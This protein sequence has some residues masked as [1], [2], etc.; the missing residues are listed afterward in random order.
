[1]EARVIIAFILSIVVFV[2]WSYLF[3]PKPKPIDPQTSTSTTIPG[4]PAQGTG[5]QARKTRT[6]QP[7]GQTQAA[8]AVRAGAYNGPIN[9]IEVNTDSYTARFTEDGGR[10]VSFKL[11][12]YREE[13]K[14]DSPPKELVTVESVRELPLKTFFLNNSRPGLKNA[15]FAANKKNLLLDAES[16]PESLTFTYDEPG[17]V[18]IVKTYT[19]Y[20]DS[21]LMDLDVEI[22][23]QSNETLDDS[24]VLELTSS[25]FVK[26]TG[27]RYSFSGLGVLANDELSEIK[28][29]KLEKGMKALR[30]KKY[31]LDW[32]GYE[33]QYFMATVIPEDHDSTKLRAMLISE[34]NLEEGVRIQL[35]GAPIRLAPG[36]SQI[37]KYNLYYGPKLYNSLKTLNKKLDRAVYFGWFDIVSK[38]LMW[39]MLHIYKVVQNYGLAIILLTLF[40]KAIF[41]PLTAK[42]YKSM[43]AMQ[44]LAPK[45][46]K[47]KEK[48]KDDR[49][50]MNRE[51]MQLYKT[52]KVNPLGGCL[53]ML[54][55]MP[56]FIGFYRLLDYSLEL[57]HAPF[58]LWIQDLSAPE[59]LFHLPFKVPYM[60]EPT[61]IPVLTILMGASW[62]LQQKLSPTT[63]D[64]TQARIMMFMPIVFTVIFVNFPAGLVLYWFVNNLLSIGQQLYTNKLTS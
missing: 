31:S 22:I 63:G 14:K 52:Y 3:P 13:A 53:P 64:P 8:P 39:A 16:G 42:S 45:M 36:S 33:N 54:I 19:F 49:V 34:E 48:Y 1:M 61:G 6:P 4:A 43:K 23:N 15:Y 5:T 29:A 24:L 27:R 9:E 12:Q 40:I 11:K 58:L 26:S 41:W 51:T 60:M 37:F 62:M 17:G 30:Q 32:A 21:Y 57:R 35:I 59:R 18:Q 2:G 50:A 7:Q 44:Q 55:Q 28:L 56:V 46:A 47:L 10:L 38:P 25:S 20:A